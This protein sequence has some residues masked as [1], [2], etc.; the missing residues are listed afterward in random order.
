MSGFGRVLDSSRGRKDRRFGGP[1]AETLLQCV[2]REV[3]S[4]QTI[5]Y[6]IRIFGDDQHRGDLPRVYAGH[7]DSMQKWKLVVLMDR[8]QRRKTASGY[9]S[10]SNKQLFVLNR[11]ANRVPFYVAVD[12]NQNTALANVVQITRPFMSLPGEQLCESRS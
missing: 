5:C 7:S 1:A 8:K 4:E 12:L 10:G 11:Q 2:S 9:W 3:T 6:P